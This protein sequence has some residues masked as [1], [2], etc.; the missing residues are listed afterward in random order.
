MTPEEPLKEN[1]ERPPRDAG[2]TALVILAILAIAVVITYL[3]PIL[4][5]LLIAV[6]VYYATRP[7]ADTLV[8]WRVPSS[9][10]YLTL[11]LL[12]AGVTTI[13][14][15]F[16]YNEVTTF[17]SEW[18]RYQARLVLLVGEHAGTLKASLEEMVNV[19]ASEVFTYLFEQGMHS[20]ELLIM[21]F[22]YLLFLIL[23]SAKLAGRVRRAFPGERGE[24]I[25]AIGRKIRDGMET[26]MKV[27]T[28]VS[29]GMAIMAA[30]VMWMFGLE[31]WLLWA[32]LFFVLN[33]ITYIGS[34]V[35]CVPP[36]VFAYLDFQSPIRA[37]ILGGLIVATRILWIDY[38]EIRL[39]GKHLNIDSVLLFVWLAYWGWAWGVVGLVLA[40]PMLASLKI[41]LTSL[42][43][44][45]GWAELMSED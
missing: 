23:G 43:Q 24:R 45:R 41:V 38:I 16:V 42:E 11:L 17:R 36:I 12:S 28:F 39:S 40:Y 2:T 31:H 34:I 10:A 30:L 44:T 7:A 19:S 18:P 37:T 27:K 9:L 1:T 8:R 15:L 32:V 26:F 25:L 14:V 6:F 5:P 35:A 3:G 22:F 33:Y 29:I 20:A 4:K 21:A 13:V